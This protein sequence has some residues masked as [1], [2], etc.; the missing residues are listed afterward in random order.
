MAYANDVRVSGNGF[1]NALNG[2]RAA[3]A[4]RFANYQVFRA[5][6]AE[7]EVLSDR[8]LSDMGISRSMIKRIAIEAA[9]GNK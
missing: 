1:I 8:E 3:V 6:V 9:Y 7:L 5:T 4:E 2:F